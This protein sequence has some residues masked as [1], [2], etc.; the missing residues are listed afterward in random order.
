MELTE[1]LDAL[2]VGTQSR[3]AESASLLRR[4]AVLVVGSHRSGTSA[5]ARVLS[6]VGCDLPKHLNP[7][8]EGDNELGF[9]EPD[10]VVHAHNAFLASIGS[11]WDDPAALPD[12]AFVSAA[13]LELRQQLGLLLPE[14]YG[15]SPLFVVKDPR[16]S[17]LLPLWFAILEQL[18]VAP[19]TAIAVRNPLEVAASLKA[20]DGF[21]TTKSLLV[22]LRHTIES[23]L[24]SR[25]RPRSIVIYDELLRNWQG[26][27][28]R[29][30]EDLGVTWPGRSHRAVVEIEQFLSEHHRHQ[31][32]D[33]REVEGRADVVSWV[34][35]AYFALR[36]SDP[37]HVFDQVR[38]ELAQADIAFGPILEEL[39][40]ERQAAQEERREAAAARDA[41]AEDL[42]ARD[43]ALEARVAE[44]QQLQEEVRGLNEV[45]AASA[46]QAAA[47]DTELVALY[48]ERDHLARE[49]ERIGAEAARLT[50][51]VEAARGRADAAGSEA[52][53][54]REELTTAYI[55][56][57][58]LRNAAD[59]AASRAA[60]LEAN[61]SA[62]REKLLTD[63]EAARAHIERLEGQAASANA[64]HGA[65]EAQA[66]SDRGELLHELEQARA[67]TE[68]LTARVIAAESEVAA[69][70]A[71][72]L[73][74]CEAANA[75][76]D[77]LAK[78]LEDKSREAEELAATADE[79]L[80]IADAELEASRA[81]QE[82][83]QAEVTEQLAEQGQLLI[84]VEQLEEALKSATASL[85]ESDQRR[86]EFDAERSR[87]L[88]ELEV[89]RTELETARSEVARLHTELEALKSE[90]ASERAAFDVL[91]DA[92]RAEENRL[93][94]ELETARTHPKGLA[95]HTS[96]LEAELAA[97]RALLQTLQS[98]TK[99]RSSR[100][101]TLSQ[102][103]T[104]LLPPTRTK[105]NYLREYLRLRRSG[106]FDVDS[107]LLANPDVL[108]AGINPLMHY[109]QYGRRE[110]RPVDGHSYRAYGKVAEVSSSGAVEP[111]AGRVRSLTVEEGSAGAEE[112]DDESI[113]RASGLFDERFYLDQNAD[114]RD[115]GIDP[116]FHYVARGHA[117]GRD[118]SAAF[119][120]TYY[121]VKY[122]EGSPA[123]NPLIHYSTLGRR[124]GNHVTPGPHDDADDVHARI[125]ASVRPGDNFEERH[126]EIAAGSRPGVKALAFYLPQFHAIAENDE[127]WGSGFTDW[128]NVARGTP[129]FEGHY[130]PRIPRDLG[131]YD[132]GQQ[133]VLRR[134][135]QLA[136][137]AGLHGFVFYYYWFDGKR[138]LEQPLERLLLDQSL[139]FPF[140]LMW[141]NENWTRRWDGH[142]EEILIEQTYGQEREVALID[143]LQRHFADP[144]YMRIQGR[145]VLLVYRL[146]TIPDLR[147]SVKRWRRVWKSRHGEEPLILGAQAFGNNADP[148]SYALDGA[149][150]FPPHKLL[151]D[152]EVINSKLKILDPSFQG[153]VVSYE[154]AVHESLSRPHPR[155]PL[156]K[157]AMPSW[158]NDPRREGQGM[159][160]HGSTPGLYERW[161]RGLADVAATHPFHGESL[162]FINAWNEWAEGAY[163]EPDLHYGSA[164]LN[165]TARAL[166]ATSTQHTLGKILIVGHDA[167]RF[168]AQQLAWHI[169][170]LFRSQ[171]GYEVAYM[172]LGGGEMIAEYEEIGVVRVTGTGR[173]AVEPYLAQLRDAG[174]SVA[175]TNT[176]AASATVPQLNAAG[177]RV[178]SLVHELGGIIGEYG[179]EDAIR[180]GMD[181]SDHIVV[182]AALVGEELARRGVTSRERIVI[183]PQ[184]LYQQFDATESA[185][186]KLSRELGIPQDAQIV[187]NVGSGDL[188]KGMDIFVHVA[189]LAA[190][191]A[192]DLHFIW[193]GNVHEPTA[194]WLQMDVDGD[195]AARLHFVP[196][197][198]EIGEFFA[199]A[200]VFFLSSRED[201]YPSVVLEAMQAGLPV[202]GFSG[203][204]G[205][206][207]LLAAHG[208]VVD[209]NDLQRLVQVL[210]RAASEDDA[211]ARAARRAVI[212][213]DFR[214]D[215]YCFD[216]ARLLDPALIKVSVIVPNFN[217][218]EF[219]D[220]RL[221]SIFAQNYPVF[222][223]I[224]LD[225]GSTDGSRKVVDDVLDRA[226]R[227]VT[228][229]ANDRNSGSVFGQWEAGVRLARGDYV[230]IAEAD[231]SSKPDFLRR[232]AACA[233]SV[234]TLAFAFCDSV[235]ID[236]HGDAV[237]DSYKPYYG[238]VVGDLM[239][240]DFV[241]E[242]P[243]F[244]RECL[245]E[246]NLVLNASSVLWHRQCLLDTLRDGESQKY[247]MAGDWYL[248]AAAAASGRRVAYVSEPLNL[249]RRHA[250]A[251]T[252]TLNSEQH[253][254]E[255]E[256][257]Q[258]FVAD[259]IGANGQMRGRMDAYADRLRD[260]FGLSKTS[261]GRTPS[262]R[263]QTRR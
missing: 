138:L 89:A 10:P 185:R 148:R 96:R 158:D 128:R 262:R 256:R 135:V 131:F 157:T 164:Y 212:E 163:L 162:V 166:C 70:R 198:E 258:A 76:A 82:Q 73:A 218:A 243:T 130:Q 134:Q 204:S 208:Y 90:A 87:L 247:R 120:T 259:A 85:S 155:F 202:V 74:D 136:R 205:T 195:V 213:S 2:A 56:V 58:R 31:V 147:Q 63:L 171:F 9:W 184:G 35:E 15:T 1:E 38:D 71:Q 22:W 79:L 62:E 201:P 66:A 30:G 54:M 33:W 244:V 100:R 145:P 116:V 190:Q 75:V 191:A 101:R 83:L 200:D 29:V 61:A 105:L 11:S 223:I 86:A 257:V 108:A 53:G 23:E 25:G 125:R 222:E 140:C 26:V 219:L 211:E 115:A 68:R 55:E 123:V 173:E 170:R 250:G 121:R 252:A 102:L 165:A 124:A 88:S 149:F 175:L 174:H 47:P 99:R 12:G 245:S 129:R 92:G 230:W 4:R 154:D 179:L 139:D 28:T 236:S 216:L 217:Y 67:D 152:V 72:L 246:R 209:R 240:R 221:E 156:V 177:F 160:V 254:A 188:R 34:K 59:E 48:A 112:R 39:R 109:V 235:P 13:A 17:R 94:A 144:R 114:V 242:G 41:L 3:S 233:A 27:L 241:L 196:Y 95:A 172:L 176:A 255:V 126:P 37:G 20:R 261:P 225:D 57:E 224:V 80:S 117:E 36:D 214:L 43:F 194:R 186:G 132:L 189:K 44:V 234:E 5:L 19:V 78:Q 153:Q 84:L 69:E 122:L 65:L 110:G 21:T 81:K 187:L 210:Q 98:V 42:Q 40:L 178:V 64:A 77:R 220:D 151:T 231:D 106:E 14:E 97:H 215:D 113:V 183:R 8:V 52:A 249:H 168:G 229:V 119:S 103:G 146:D 51:E 197:T 159:V 104:W 133:G 111:E 118:P 182:A 107:Y 199:A 18:Q 127:W 237:G 180:E 93:A 193:V 203:A 238:E 207:D 50:A 161:L 137:E 228:V 206:E 227:F 260:Q 141:A 248:Y 232:L 142:E 253:V 167:H 192:P 251:I 239:N 263:W 181:K 16:I 143:D 7:P 150:E 49:V 6:L 32:F 60:A 91:R 226:G 24:H 169:G 46:S 45:I